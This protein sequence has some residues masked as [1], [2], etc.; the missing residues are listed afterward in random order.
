MAL[1]VEHQINKI[2]KLK[3]VLTRN[4]SQKPTPETLI[5]SLE[6]TMM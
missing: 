6:I 2:F 4:I 3:I 5:T 1:D